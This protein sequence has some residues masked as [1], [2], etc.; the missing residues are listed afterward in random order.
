M[1]QDK[2][3]TSVMFNYNTA[4]QKVIVNNPSPYFLNFYDISL[5]SGPKNSLYTETLTVAPYSTEAFTPKINFIP[6]E[7]KYSLINDF[8]ANQTYTA[9]IDSAKWWEERY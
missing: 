6:T 1:S 5:N 4:T 7:A 3:F 2:A 9:K 8:G